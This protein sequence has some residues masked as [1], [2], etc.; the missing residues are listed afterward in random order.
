MPY[1][2][3][4][5]S[6]NRDEM[7]NKYEDSDAFIYEHLDNLGHTPINF[8]NR[9]FDD[10]ADVTALPDAV[11]KV[12]EANQKKLNYEFKVNDHHVWQYHRNNGFSKITIHSKHL[13]AQILRIIEG[14]VETAYTINAAYIKQNFNT[15]LVVGINYYPFEYDIYGLLDRVMNVATVIVVPICLC[16]GFPIFLLSIVTEK[17]KRLLEIMKINGMKMSN[18]WMVNYVFNYLFYL[19]TVAIFYFWGSYVFQF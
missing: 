19:L 17:E 14:Q 7:L 1:F 16:M 6:F 2:K 3:D 8:V 18:Y 5:E 9:T 13:D 4:W 11:Y 12:F 10:N 15:T